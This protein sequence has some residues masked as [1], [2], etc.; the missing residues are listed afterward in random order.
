MRK[1]FFR[2]LARLNR[3]LLPRIS[4]RNLNRLSKTEKL[5]VAWRYWVTCNAL[6]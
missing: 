4:R 2:F 1:V 6:D 5:I 3:L